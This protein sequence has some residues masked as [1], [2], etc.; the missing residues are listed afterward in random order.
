MI[1]HP[2]TN[3]FCP[4]LPEG[5]VPPSPPADQR[6]RARKRLKKHMST[7]TGRVLC[8]GSAEYAVELAR[9]QG[10]MT[11]G[12]QDLAGLGI[13]QFGSSST[14]TD[15]AF[16]Y[17]FETTSWLDSTAAA[18]NLT[19]VAAP[20]SNTGK[21]GN[22]IYLNGSQ[23][24]KHVDATAYNMASTDFAI[25]SW[26]YA[27]AAASFMRAYWKG[28][29]TALTREW[30]MFTDGSSHLS[31]LVQGATS[32][33]NVVQISW[34]SVISGATWTFTESYFTLSTGVARIN[35]N[36][37]TAL[38]SGALG[39]TVLH[40]ATVFSVGDDTSGNLWT[41]RIDS[42]GGW[43]RL[44]TSAER[45]YLYNSGNGADPPF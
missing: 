35:I 36:N 26:V 21:I 32:T 3:L 5:F 13:Q 19:G 8:P 2:A 45:A 27:D 34:G 9:L 17:E 15:A 16:Y 33:S 42:T 20:T 24:A 30:G 18:N 43:K 11:G 38:A 12:A 4:S 23:S 25:T 22:A 10:G 37:G 6:M 28:T 7:Y 40:G 29:N 14:L 44:L 41:G 39:D 31:F 1:W